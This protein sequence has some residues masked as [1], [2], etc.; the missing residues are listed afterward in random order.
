VLVTNLGRDLDFSGW[1]SPVNPVDSRCRHRAPLERRTRTDGHRLLRSVNPDN[2]EWHPGGKSKAL[3]LADCEAMH[4]GMCSDDCTFEI[5]DFTAVPSATAALDEGGMI[6]V[7]HEADLVA[8]WLVRHRK[9]KLASLTSD[10]LL[11]E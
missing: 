5:A 1:G 3:S 2:I 8:V 9:A 7:G 6:A 4:A 11:V 10:R